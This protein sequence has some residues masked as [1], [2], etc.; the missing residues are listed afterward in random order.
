MNRSMGIAGVA[1][2]TNGQFSDLIGAQAIGRDIDAREAATPGLQD[3]Y[4]VELRF[5]GQEIH[6][7]MMR[8]LAIAGDYKDQRLHFHVY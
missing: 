4:D 6:L 5:V 2:G 8:R 7:A 3:L 1:Q